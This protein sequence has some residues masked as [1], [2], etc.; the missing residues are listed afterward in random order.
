MGS[1]FAMCEKSQLMRNAPMSLGTPNWPVTVI[2]S[3]ETPAARAGIIERMKSTAPGALA[4]VAPLSVGVPAVLAGADAGAAAGAAGG[5]FCRARPVQRTL[6]TNPLF[7]KTCCFYRAFPLSCLQAP[8]AATCCVRRAHPSLP[9]R[10]AVCMSYTGQWAC[11]M[12]RHGHKIHRLSRTDHEQECACRDRPGRAD[13]AGI[14]GWHGR[15]PC[16]EAAGLRA[17]LHP[18]GHG[19]EAVRRLAHAARFG[20]AGREPA[21]PGAARQA[22]QPA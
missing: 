17:A 9:H 1:S 20:R 18:R 22:V 10:E 6:R 16:V 14:R 5:A 15:A 2:C 13:G 21:D 4:T 3:C 19:A 7:D 12:L 11:R 8:T